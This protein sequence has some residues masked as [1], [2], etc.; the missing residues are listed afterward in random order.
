MYMYGNFKKTVGYRV[1]LQDA[2][3]NNGQVP[4]LDDRGGVEKK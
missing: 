3:G 1:Y 4:R 2:G